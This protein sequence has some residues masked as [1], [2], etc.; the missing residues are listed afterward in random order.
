MRQSPWSSTI[1]GTPVRAARAAAAS[2]GLCAT[3]ARGRNAA[4]SRLMRAGSESQNRGP[5]NAVRGRSR[6]VSSPRE[7]SGE[8]ATTRTSKTLGERIPFQPQARR[9]RQPIPIA[10]DEQHSRHRA[11]RSRI[12]S[13]CPY[14][15]VGVVGGDRRLR[16]CPQ[17]RPELAVAEVAPHGLRERGRVA[18]LHEEAVLAVD[19]QLADT[20]RARRDH[21]SPDGQRL[22]DRVRE[23]LPRRREHRRVGRRG[24]ARAPPHAAEGR[25]TDAL[26]AAASRR[27][28]SGPSPAIS[29]P[30]AVEQAQSGERD[31]E[32]L[33][34]REAAGERE[35]G[36]SID[37]DRTLPAA[38]GRAGPGS[39]AQSRVRPA[40][41]SETTR[42]RMNPPGMTT[43]AARRRSASRAERRSAA[44]APPPP[45]WNSPTSPATRPRRRARSN[46]GSAV[47]LSTSGVR[48]TNAPS[49]ERPNMPV[50]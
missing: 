31:A 32:I 4:T 2:N 40:R 45:A 25:G 38:R 47:S 42:S 11:A 19:D 36:P 41:P 14:T 21:R 34:R 3:I 18:R 10:G 48:A 6:K 23:V 30:N 22:D 29:E 1:T 37:P 5:S 26:A 50:E 16:R 28:R 33:L 46:A 12:D 39:A 15:A 9:Q 27:A 13:S 8:A 44:S 24:A 43:W 20:A 7:A 17:T 35:V 49:D